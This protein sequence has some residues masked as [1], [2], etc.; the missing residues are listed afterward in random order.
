LSNNNDK[1]MLQFRDKSC[2]GYP[3][4]VHIQTINGK[5]IILPC[6]LR[7]MIKDLFT[8]A[9]CRICFDKMNVFSDITVGDPWGI[10]NVDRIKGESIA[11]IRTLKGLSIFLQA[12]ESNKILARELSYENIFAG[13]NIEAK[14]QE[15]H[16]FSGA[17]MK[18]GYQL[19]NY[20]QRVQRETKNYKAGL[21]LDKIKYSLSF[22]EHPTRK[23]L[24]RF[25]NKQLLKQN[26]RRLYLWPFSYA[27]R[28]IYK[29]YNKILKR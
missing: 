26:Q 28:L 1:K 10:L 15:W 6:K 17:W 22:D 9:R 2:G 18:L 12:F 5:S 4:N 13:Q 7:M 11:V 3:G 29:A 20:Y 21:Y 14:Y 19:P 8:P 25:A 16:G 27:K 23:E 24:F